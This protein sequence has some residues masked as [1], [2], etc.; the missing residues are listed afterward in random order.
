MNKYSLKDKWILVESAEASQGFRSLIIDPL[1]SPELYMAISVCG[2]RSLVLKV[3]IEE[4]LSDK[5]IKKQK[6]SL[7]WFHESNYM[8]LSLLDAGFQELF[9]DLVLSMYYSVKNIPEKRKCTSEFVR[10]F[11]KWIQLFEDPSRE[12]L[13]YYQVQG[14]F[15]ELLYISEQLEAAEGCDVNEILTSWR[16]PYDEAYDFTLPHENIEVKTVRAEAVK[17]NIASEYQLDGELGKAHKLLIYSV[18]KDLISGRSIKDIAYEVR[19][20]IEFELGDMSIFRL[21]LRQK[22]LNFENLHEYDNYRFAPVRKTEYDCLIE[23]FPRIVRSYLDES[24]ADVT[25][26]LNI[27]KLEKYRL[28][29]EVY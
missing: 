9:D 6:I 19:A 14:L 11:T 23:G 15:G 17:V 13:S 27:T 2:N 8:V 25:Y 24:L 20:I 22:N 4:K 21:A 18:D 16:G 28:S 29:R 1:I 5:V 7:E 10:T 3:P 12:K 26:S